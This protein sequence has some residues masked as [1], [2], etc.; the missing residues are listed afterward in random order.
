MKK[1]YLV[2]AFLFLFTSAA[3]AADAPS[4]QEIK[5]MLIEQSLNSYPGNCP[6]PYSR[7]RAGRMCGKRSAYSRPGGRSPLCYEHDISEEMVRGFRGKI[8]LHPR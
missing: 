2:F 7:D 1:L 3:H 4:D 5:R 6:C 8:F